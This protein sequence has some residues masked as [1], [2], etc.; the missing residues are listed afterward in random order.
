MI[1]KNTQ[2]TISKEYDAQEM[3]KRITEKVYSDPKCKAIKERWL[4]EMENLK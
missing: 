1:N 4:K 2:D 3:W